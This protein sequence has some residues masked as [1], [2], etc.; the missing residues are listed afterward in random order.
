[1]ASA[2]AMTLNL[3][4]QNETCS[5]ANGSVYASVSGGVPPYTYL[6]GGGETTESISGLS[7]GTYSVTVTDFLGEQ[8]SDQAT[9]ISEDYGVVN[10]N[11]PHSYCPGQNYHEF[12]FPPQPPGVPMDVSPWSASQ[13]IIDLVPP[14][15]GPNN[16]YLDPGPIPAG[17]G[18]SVAFWDANGCSGTLNFTA[19]YPITS[20]PSFTVV[21]AQ[22][23]CTNIATGTITFTSTPVAGSDTYYALRPEGSGDDLQYLNGFQAVGT[24]VYAFT[25][26]PPGNYWLK[27]RLGLTY[28][29]LQGGSCSTDSVLVTVPD[30]GPTCGRITGSTYMDYNSNCIDT[31]ANASNVVVEIQPGPI[32]TSSGG[33][34]SVVVPNGNYTMTTSAA[35]ITQ[36]CP[37]SAAVNGNTVTSNI[38]HQPTIPLD[39]A[40][41]LA[42]GP[43]RPGFQ[44]HYSMIVQNLS[45][46]ASGATTTTFT[47][48]PAVSF[49]SAWPTG[50]V[51]GNTITW[52][53]ASLAIF[54]EREYQIQLQV[55]PDV[56]LIGTELLASA[57]VSTANTDGDLS[58]NST[59]AT[60]TVTGSYD[61]NDK[62]AYTSTRASE[63]LYFINEDDWIDYVIRFQNTGTDTA[64]NIVVTDTLPTTLDPATI[65]LVTASHQHTWNVQG[66]G[67][68]KFIFPNIL[69]PDSNVNEPL[70]HGLIS[71]RIR[72]HL[73]ITPTTVIENIANIYFDF[74]PPVI[75][76]PSV[77]VA[78]FSTGITADPATDLVLAPVPASD[79]L[80]IS[81]GTII[82]MITIL[83]ADGRSIT[84]QRVRSTTTTL[85]VSAL[86]SGTYFLIT[87]NADGSMHRTPF[88]VVHY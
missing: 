37:A 62:T 12:F 1:M 64:F 45:S 46:S 33:G 41:G 35:A 69:L 50:S 34:Y 57:A 61:P 68:L 29:L 2:C 65:S 11:F 51:V 82:D 80:R 58:N 79:Q 67:T 86:P 13:G 74:N 75:T 73:P 59:N 10:Y 49:I 53:Q 15:A 24:D 38:G 32:Y 20:W 54:Q 42:S 8:V 5:Y 26:L 4:V 40:I 39:L 21:D 31:E 71:F 83:T 43:A 52:T 70:S 84:Q 18:Q 87:N 56:G 28:S 81:S 36:S 48:D 47:F 7:P 44:L 76:E 6:W 14:P 23:S 22:G 3:Q 16:Y 30:I 85:V 25:S 72:P 17:S 88:T 78:E 9:V 27:H 19:G 77:L 66:Q 60:I 55:P 63:S